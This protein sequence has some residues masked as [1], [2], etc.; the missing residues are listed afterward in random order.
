MRIPFLRPDFVD[1]IPSELEPGVLY[2]SIKYSVTMH[3]CACGCGERVALPLHPGQWKITY[4]GDAISLNPSVGNVGTVCNS[5]YWVRAGRI[6]WYADISAHRAREG[7][8]HDRRAVSR[9]EEP[10]ASRP[11][12]PLAR[13]SSRLK[14]LV[15]RLRQK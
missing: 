5:H 4:D 6:D 1:I 12:T 9:A 13:N 14:R 8:L 10:A 7:R 3:L 11:P 15:D 2:V